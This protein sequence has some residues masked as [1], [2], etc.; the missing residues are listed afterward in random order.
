MNRKACAAQ[1]EN[2]SYQCATK[3]ERG[4]NRTREWSREGVMRTKEARKGH[5]DR[6][7]ETVAKIKPTDP[8][9]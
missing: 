9:R 4:G 2:T 8:L 5:V 7:W 3:A 6:S 1:R